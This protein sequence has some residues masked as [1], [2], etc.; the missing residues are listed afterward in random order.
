MESMIKK[1]TLIKA[2]SPVEIENLIVDI[3]QQIQ[4]LKEGGDAIRIQQIQKQYQDELKIKAKWG[5]I[6][7]LKKVEKETIKKALLRFNGRLDL[8]ASILGVT[9]K[10]LI[11]KI[12][13]HH[14]Q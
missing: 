13:D 7:I 3:E 2:D 9:K 8:I 12:K 10:E 14:L 5:D 11:K 1:L 6:N 4:I